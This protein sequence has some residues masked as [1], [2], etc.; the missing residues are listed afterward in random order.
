[1]D[2]Y[3]YFPKIRHGIQEYFHQLE[4]IRQ[5]SKHPEFFE[6]IKPD[7]VKIFDIDPAVK[8]LLMLTKNQIDPYKKLPFESI[9]INI[10]LEVDGFV[11]KGIV[12]GKDYERKH[13]LINSF[14]DFSQRNVWCE[15]IVA[16]HPETC[17]LI[18]KYNVVDS[19]SKCDKHPKKKT[20]RKI[21]IFVMNFLDFLNQPEVEFIETKRTEK[22][23]QKRIKK[24]KD[25]LPSTTRVVVKGDLKRHIDS[26]HRQLSGR[27][28]SHRFWVRGHFMRLRDK[29]RFR[30]MY[31]LY[32]MGLLDNKYSIDND[33]FLMRWKLPYIK[34]RGI[35][36][37]K[38]Y[39]L[40][41]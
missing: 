23:N 9:A 4:K 11:F 22:T 29:N 21:I 6:R 12:V 32:S 1:M 39:E 26:Y 33:G 2:E 19:L 37:N 25:P 7:K 17:E 40:Q 16:I 3:N 20:A 14:T 35:L 5:I 41:K 24:G 27:T 8:R 13:L 31:D 34:G 15:D 38:T 36:I 30:R 10:D 28:F 18:S